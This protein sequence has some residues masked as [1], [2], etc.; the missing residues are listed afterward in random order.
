MTRTA[1][2]RNDVPLGIK[3]LVL[4][5]LTMF[6]LACVQ[7]QRPEVHEWWFERGPV[8]PHDTFPADC[9][10]CH[11]GDGWTT[12][13]EDFS[14][15]HEVETGVALLGAHAEAE[16]LRCHNDRGPA[17]VYAAQGCVGCHEDVHRTQLGQAC[18]RCHVETSWR[19]KEEIAIHTRVGFPLEG[20]HLT[21]QCWECHDGADQGVFTGAPRDCDVCHAETVTLTM[22]PD[23]VAQG[24]TASCERCHIP[25][26]WGGDGFTHSSFPLVASHR[27]VDCSE[28]HIGGVF[29]G[30]PSACVDCHLTEYQGTDDPDHVQA[31]F[32]TDCE[33]CH[34]ET[35][36]EDGTYPHRSFALSGAHAS[37]DC[38][39]CHVGGVFAGLPS[40]CIDCHQA[41]YDGADDPD[42]RDAGF[43]TDCTQCH[44]TTAWEG[45]DFAHDVWRLTGAHTQADCNECHSGGIY[46]GLPSDCVDCHLDDFQGT[47]DPDHVAGGFQTSCDDCH[48]TTTW[49]RANFSHDLWRLTGAHAGTDC[50]ECHGGGV[51]EGTTTECSGCHL[52]DYRGTDDPDHGALGYPLE[53]D[54]CHTTLMWDRA[55]FNHDLWPL[56]GQHAVAACDECHGGGVFEGTPQDCIVCHFP[57]WQASTNPNHQA[58]GL[59]TTCQECHDTNDWHDATYGHQVWSLT[60]SHTSAEC[61]DCHASGTY[62]GLPST[63]VSCHLSDYR[64]TDDPDHA[65]AGFP[66][67][68]ESCHTT[69]MWE[70]ARFNHNFPIDRGDHSGLSCTECHQQ[71]R[72]FQVFSCTH[73]HEHSQREMADEHDRVRGYTWSSPACY[74]CHPDGDD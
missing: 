39:A 44:D 7:L 70:G 60:G 49:D 9:S 58:A 37:T 54:Q 57:S 63:C 47:D 2:P 3:L 71:P 13:R 46:A 30:T 73:C 42:H 52:D 72:A 61:I 59:S 19:P 31:G 28:C 4:G 33:T 22:D 1:H 48:N 69:V 35:E 14:F 21:P 68:C 25:T 56:E 74:Q 17:G 38:S 62:A 29:E 11:T 20:A 34:Q 53:C 10:L 45:A 40:D 36:W 41:D 51:F 12:L 43:P 8:I 64:S 55:N 23:H 50:I 6:A 5:V 27:T 65:A 66:T 16:C 32:G 24:W 67:S 15:D 26:T 18:A